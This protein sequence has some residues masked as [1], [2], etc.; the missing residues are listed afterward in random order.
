MIIC[1]NNNKGGVLKTTSV[2]NIAGVFALQGLKVL[3]VDCDNQS[4]VAL[5]FGGNPD[6]YRTTLYDVLINDVPPED[7]IVPVHK[8]I[9]I[10]PSNDDL[11][12]FEFDVIG[13]P[14]KY[15]EPFYLLKDALVHLREKYDFILLDTPPS[16]SLMNGNVFS[17]ADMVLIPYQPEPYSMRSLKNV[18][19]TIA[20]FKKEYNPNIEV[21]GVFRT[22]VQSNSNLHRDIIQETNRY[23]YENDIHIFETSIP[24][25]VQFAGAV[26]YDQLPATLLKKKEKGSLYFDLCKEITTKIKSESSVK[27]E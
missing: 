17:F 16:L 25:T 13:N 5:S 23:A 14:K 19:R 4:N 18:V 24:R 27:N 8:N 2:T 20:R 12:D 7:A 15:P 6:K 26:G 3:I 10:L 9:D 11:V 22:L 1:V 21:L